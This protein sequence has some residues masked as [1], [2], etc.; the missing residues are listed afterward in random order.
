[1]EGTVD[2]LEGRNKIQNGLDILKTRKNMIQ[3]GKY[4]ILY[5]LRTWQGNS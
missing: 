2:M 4:N 3:F 5:L 1:M